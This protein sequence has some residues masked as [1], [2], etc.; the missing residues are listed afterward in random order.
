MNGQSI[1]G[2]IIAKG[3]FP[4]VLDARD[5]KAR[6]DFVGIVSRYTP[7]RRSGRQFVGLCPFHSERHPSFY[8]HP[9]KKIFYCFGCGAGGDLFDFVTR[10]EGCDFLGALRIV[11]DSVGVAR[12][13]ERAKRA[14]G[15][16]RAKGAKPPGPAQQGRSHRWDNAPRP[17]AVVGSWPSLDCAAEREAE[18]V[19]EAG[20]FT[21][22]EPDNSPMKHAGRAVREAERVCD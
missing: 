3:L 6:V 15:F 22:H 2:S 17:F 16:E 14:S 7:L 11:A 4:S 18:A 5:L 13:S 12:E 1:C 20:S 9:E 19:R 10:A 21:C 8:I